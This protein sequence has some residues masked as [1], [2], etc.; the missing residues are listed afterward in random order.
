M[1]TE[2]NYLTKI[3]SSHIVNNC[4]Y[5]NMSDGNRIIPNNGYQYLMTLSTCHLKKH[6]LLTV[7]LIIDVMYYN[8]YY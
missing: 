7:D 1:D 8:H 6:Y 3:K 4:S 5:F 2:N